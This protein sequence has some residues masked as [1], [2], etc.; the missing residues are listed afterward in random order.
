MVINKLSSYPSDSLHHCMNLASP[1][2]GTT[3]S[4]VMARI[5]DKY[6][7][8][9]AEWDVT[10]TVSSFLLLQLWP[11]LGNCSFFKY[12]IKHGLKCFENNYLYKETRPR[13]YKTYFMLNSVEHEILN[14]HKY[15]I[16]R[17]SASL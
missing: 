9:S 16:S 12:C 15:K 14:A 17:N 7:R 10:V 1:P 5:K 2:N 8:P 4:V 6:G 13:G 3:S 11:V